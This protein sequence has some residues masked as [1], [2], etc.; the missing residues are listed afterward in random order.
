MGTPLDRESSLRP[1]KGPLRLI[2]SFP[3]ILRHST[4][5][6]LGPTRAL[7]TRKRTF[8]GLEVFFLGQQ[9]TSFAER[10]TS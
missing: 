6:I 10:G 8:V 3:D 5:D 1:T 2:M 7:L 4:Q 9:R